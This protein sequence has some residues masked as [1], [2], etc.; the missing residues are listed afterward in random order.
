MGRLFPV[1]RRWLLLGSLSGLLGACGSQYDFTGDTIAQTPQQQEGIIGGQPSRLSDYPSTGAILFTTI[2]SYGELTGSMLCTGTLIAPDVVLAAAHCNLAFL[3][4]GTK[5]VEY[6]FTFSLNVSE[7][8]EDGVVLPPNTTKVA[9]VVPH[10]QFVIDRVSPGLGHG[11]DIALLY[12][13][14]PVWSVEPTSMITADEVGVLRPGQPVAIVGYGRRHQA[15]LGREDAGVKFQGVT[16]IN[17][18]GRY[19]MQVSRGDPQPHKCHGDSGGPTFMAISHTDR[20][21]RLAL[22]GVTSHAYDDADCINGGVDTRVDR[23]LN[24]LTADMQLACRDGRRPA[25]PK[26]R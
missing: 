6:Y 23:Y 7:F 8:G 10:P 20:P 18:V 25:C 12:L 21:T 11:N 1:S 16:T 2:G 22:I 15:E 24:W 13:K 26:S 19:E 14:T 9:T 3:G 17:R 5:R 4:Y